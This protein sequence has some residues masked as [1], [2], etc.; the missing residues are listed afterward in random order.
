MTTIGLISPG[1]MGA[2]VGAAA[3]GN[4]REVVWAG[5]G[6]SNETHQRA[7]QAGLTDCGTLETLVDRAEIILS[8]CPPHDAEPIAMAVAEH[9]FSGIFVDC[10]AIAPAKTRTIAGRFTDF[11]DGGIVGG[12]AWQADA[13]TCLYLSGPHANKIARV[14]DNSPLHTEVISDKVGSASAMKMV[15]AAYTKGTTALLTAILG[16]AEFH[17][18]RSVLESQWGAEFTGQ[19]HK[20]LMGNSHK[21]WRFAG[22]MREIAETFE[23]AGMPVG[24]HNAAA[25]VFEQLGLFKEG[26]AE[27]I[28]ALLSE[29]RKDD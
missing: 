5:D 29:L 14:F 16:T 2:S 13:G 1:A 17:G 9:K 20:R 27:S 3:L 26:N 15:F 18:V 8:I 22:E 28:D 19:T 12:P 21:A 25:E 4:C 6:R 11:V 24:F 7:K 10:N 23:E